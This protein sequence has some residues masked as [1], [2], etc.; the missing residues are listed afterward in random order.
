MNEGQVKAV[1]GLQRGTGQEVVSVGVCS[2]LR[3]MMRVAFYHLKHTSI[4]SN[5]AL[6]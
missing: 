5:Y 3:G 1:V 2:S 6:W 4:I